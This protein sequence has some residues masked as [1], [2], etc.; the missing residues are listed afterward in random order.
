MGYCGCATRTSKIRWSVVALGCLLGV[1]FIIA[2]AMEVR[3]C[4]VCDTEGSCS[5]HGFSYTYSNGEER[6]EDS[7]GTIIEGASMFHWDRTMHIVFAYV[8]CY[9]RKSVLQR[10]LA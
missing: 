5:S 7:E 9:A 8:L 3:K 6:I 2:M 4:K 10:R 1:I